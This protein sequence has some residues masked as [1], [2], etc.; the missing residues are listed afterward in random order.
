MADLALADHLAVEGVVKKS[1]DAPEF[2][3]TV[4]LRTSQG[5]PVVVPGSKL[6][7]R[8]K[9]YVQ[10]RVAGEPVK[11]AMLLD[12]ELAFAD[13][14]ATLTIAAQE[15]AVPAGTRALFLSARAE[16]A[17]ARV[18]H[19]VAADVAVTAR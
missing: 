14:K 1:G 7:G 10:R 12:R 5:R 4:D 16:L 2:R 6:A 17:G 15:L 11:G 8:L 13:G 19:G 18:L 9:V 3:V